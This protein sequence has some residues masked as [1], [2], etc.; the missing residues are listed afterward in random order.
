MLPSVAKRVEVNVP[1]ASTPWDHA[2]FNRVGYEMTDRVGLDVRRYVQY[3]A[4]S[5]N[6]RPE[7]SWEKVRLE[8]TK[9]W[10]RHCYFAKIQ[11]APTGSVS[12]FA[13]ADRAVSEFLDMFMPA[14]AAMWSMPSVV[15]KLDASSPSAP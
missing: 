6:G 1:G 15:D 8:L 2:A 9:P 13:E 3:Y 5:L 10:V 12:D 7:N 4:F 11:L 14:V